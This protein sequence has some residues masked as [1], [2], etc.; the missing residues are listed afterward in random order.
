[1]ILSCPDCDQRYVSVFAETVDWVG[2]EDPQYW[3][4]LPVTIAEAE[5]LIARREAVNDAVLI[6]LGPGRRS[7][8]RDFPKGQPP[9]VSWGTGMFVGPHD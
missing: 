7:L 8:R 6:A 5:T 2:G 4:L 3:T 1:M 9:R